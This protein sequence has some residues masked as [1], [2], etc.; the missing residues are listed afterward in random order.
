MLKPTQKG[1]LWT[2]LETR[3]VKGRLVPLV[4]KSPHSSPELSRTR[5]G[6]GSLQPAKLLGVRLFREVVLLVAAAK[7]GQNA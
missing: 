1:V 2:P 3:A 7:N 4:S 5:A 6:Q